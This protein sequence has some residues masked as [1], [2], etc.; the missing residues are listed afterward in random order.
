MNDEP[1]CALP[2]LSQLPPGQRRRR[3]VIVVSPSP[4]PLEFIGP[5]NV[6]LM[7]NFVF[8]NSGRSDFGY[9]IELVASQAGVVYKNA[10]LRL[11]VD[12]PFSRLRGKIDT[13]LVAPMNWHELFNSSSRYLNW[14][15]ATSAKV[16][17]IGSICSAAY[18]LAEAGI[19]DGRRATTHWELLADFRTRY[20]SI[21]LEGSPLYVKDGNVYTSA[22]MTSGIDMTVALV[23]EDFGRE[24]ALRVS[25]ALVLFLNRPGNQ[26]QF[27]VPLASRLPDNPDI[28]DLQSYIYEHIDEDLRVEAL[29]ERVRMSPRNFARVFARETGM[30]PG[31]F[32]E[33]CRIEVARRHLEESSATIAEV[34]ALSGYRTTDSMRLAFERTLDASPRAYRERFASSAN[35]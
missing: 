29:A 35:A 5:L 26:A 19:L 12:K 10:G 16:R 13:L 33:H 8:E 4:D 34:A 25:Q 1:E 30:P 32:V 28:S 18:I 31:R 3:F 15:R 6:L 20:P 2:K 7:A 24:V 21:Q 9:D 27:S 23:E 17:R 14:L 11:S 22:G